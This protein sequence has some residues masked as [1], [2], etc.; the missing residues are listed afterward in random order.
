MYYFLVKHLKGYKSNW[1]EAW[2]YSDEDKAWE[3]LKKEEEKDKDDRYEFFVTK[4]ITFGEQ[5]SL[6]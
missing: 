1:C 2:M 6:F 5:I 3:R 4:S